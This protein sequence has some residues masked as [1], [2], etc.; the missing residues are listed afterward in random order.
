MPCLRF[1]SA[2]TI[3]NVAA[4]VFDE[5][6]PS[7]RWAFQPVIDG[8]IIHG[9]PT[10]VWKTGKWNKVPI[11]T[12]HNTNEGTMYVP[13]KISSSE[14]F[15]SF[16][17]TLLPHYSD[18]DLKTIEAIYPDPNGD[19]IS[20]YVETRNLKALKIGPQFKRTEAS[21]A[22]YAYVCPVRQTA[23]IVST[24]S[25]S[26]PVYV[27]HWAV[28]T[29]VKGGANHADNMYYET[30]QEDITSITEAQ[31]EISGI[32]H[33]YI[34]SFITSGDPNAIQGRFADRPKWEKYTKKT[35]KVMT[36]GKG[37]DE[38]A[39]GVEK[40]ISAQMAGSEWIKKEC[41]FWWKKSGHTEVFVGYQ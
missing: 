11:L 41:E 39:G 15:K 23:E 37:N 21:Y 9:Q 32:Y 13:A 36:L 7:L 40:G 34:T 38:R 28:N 33:A 20:P 14:E 19:K 10:E 22:H 31:R 29:T 1:Q 27:Y 12:G 24:S 16:W 26:P 25:S 3:S 5:Y 8:E 30:F 18:K 2:R 6:Y 17:H 35:K 4:S